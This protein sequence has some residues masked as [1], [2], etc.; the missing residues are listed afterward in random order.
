MQNLVVLGDARHSLSLG[1]E[2]AGAVSA[3]VVDQAHDW[4]FVLTEGG[5]VARV[6]TGG[7]AAP[8]GGSARVQAVGVPAW[9][10]L[11]KASG[12]WRF[13]F[14]LSTQDRLLFVASSGLI[15]TASP[16]WDL[17]LAGA[18]GPP[19]VECEVIGEVGD[20]I[21]GAS[22]SADGQ[23]LL[24]A[25]GAGALLALTTSSWSVLAEVPSPARPA[26]GSPVH[27]SW[28][29][30]GAFAASLAAEEG[31]GGSDDAAAANTAVEAAGPA[32]VL[33]C[34]SDV[35]GLLPV[36]PA[37]A[38]PDATD[39]GA[40]A[41][42]GSDASQAASEQPPAKDGVSATEHTG[43]RFRRPA[44]AMTP[45]QAAAA[46]SASASGGTL[47]VWAQTLGLHGTGRLED[48]A[49]LHAVQLGCSSAGSAAVRARE[50]VLLG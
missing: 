45:A 2:G 44:P 38:G 34:A 19:A 33:R 28:R 35:Q 8:E 37:S 48:G 47:R 20:G 32:D 30:D 25:T 46:P 5:L 49:P 50:R 14:S 15:V 26:A 27:L 18:A 12:P 29:P 3:V 9:G 36:D 10:M 41:A 22:V 13:G 17:A 39:A 43:R 21:S 16:E 4:A 24:L 40:A 1:D 7:S 31:S 6:R 42:A 23:L 11:P